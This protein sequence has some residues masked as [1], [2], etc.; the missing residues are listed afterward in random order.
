MVSKLPVPCIR[1]F[2]GNPFLSSYISVIA[3]KAGQ[4][5]LTHPVDL[6]LTNAPRLPTTK[7]QAIIIKVIFIH[8]TTNPDVVDTTASAPDFIN[9]PATESA[10]ANPNNITE[11]P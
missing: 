1:W 10:A 6:D 7:F 2:K 5:T 9:F 11:A 4:V 8:A 3:R